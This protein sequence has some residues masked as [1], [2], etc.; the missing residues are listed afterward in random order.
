MANWGNIGSRGAIDDRRGSRMIALGGGGLSL[1]GIVLLV[2]FNYLSGGNITDVVPQIIN[3]SSNSGLYE[4][5][6]Q[7]EG[8]DTYEVFASTVLGSTNDTWTEIFNGMNKTYTPPRLVLFRGATQSGCGTATAD[9]GPHYCPLDQ[10]IYLD[11]TFFEALQKY[12][13]AGS[14]D[15]AQAYVIAHEV[16][17]HVQYE[18]GTL[19]AMN[20]EAEAAPE[21]ANALSVTQE[22]Q[23]DCYA[24]VW[25]YS[26][27]DQNVFET[28]EVREAMDAAGAVGDD[29]IQAKTGGRVTPES[30]TH[31]SSEDRTAAFTKGFEGGTLQSC[32][33]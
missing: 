10:T 17:H 7:Y 22:L 19:E 31:G 3:Q 4:D 21:R 12:F 25:A 13:G 11:E 1:T 28:G 6:T 23:A 33:G 14:A 18:L 8:A 16:G 26:L 30:W 2:V 20:R 32:A 29:R 15:V 9:V 24:G 27:Q 5:T